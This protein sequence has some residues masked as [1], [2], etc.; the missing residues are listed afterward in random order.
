MIEL[1]SDKNNSP[2]KIENLLSV[3]SSVNKNKNLVN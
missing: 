2:E 1:T 3:N